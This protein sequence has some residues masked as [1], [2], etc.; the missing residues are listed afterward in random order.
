[1][2]KYCVKVLH[3][4]LIYCLFSLKAF[5]L[6]D[7]LLINTPTCLGCV[8]PRLS[9]P[10]QEVVEIQLKSLE[11][12]TCPLQLLFNCSSH[13][14]T[15]TRAACVHTQSANT[16]CLI[17][18]LPLPLVLLSCSCSQKRRDEWGR[19]GGG[20][21][22]N[23]SGGGVFIRRWVEAGVMEFWSIVQAGQA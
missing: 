15:H 18:F 12:N 22:M 23:A 11:V 8:L 14:L 20:L 10:L 19:G 17:C 3:A 13:I 5:L 16:R 9:L 2:R 6:L 21:K 1:M 7:L 4:V